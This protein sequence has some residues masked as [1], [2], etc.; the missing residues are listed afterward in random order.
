MWR[1]I[2][3]QMCFVFIG[4]GKFL[5]YVNIIMLNSSVPSV[6]KLKIYVKKTAKFIY[7]VKVT[8]WL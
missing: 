3:L 8:S 1:V 6:I 7:S 5:Q 2:I 4:Y